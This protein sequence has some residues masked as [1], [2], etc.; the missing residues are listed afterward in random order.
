MTVIAQRLCID[1]HRRTAR[2]ELSAEVDLGSV[3]PDHDALYAAVDRDHLTQAMAHLAPRHREVLGLREGKGWSYQHIADHLD[4]PVTTI[5]ALLHR[6][7]H[8]LR[9]EFLTVSSGSRL[10]GTPIIGWLVF[11]VTRLRTKISGRTANQLVPL[12]G[13]AAAGVAAIG[14]VLNPLGAA[15]TVPTLTRPPAAVSLASSATPTPSN[16][17]IVVPPTVSSASAAS[18]A[19]A[20]AD[21]PRATVSAPPPPIA[22]A[23][24]VAVHSGPAGTKYAQQA[25]SEQPV[26]VDLPGVQA[27]LNPVQTVTDVLNH[28]PGG[29][30]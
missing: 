29:T 11:R 20:A 25:N 12:A 1:H 30:P 13:S 18:A 8:A 3:E 16:V 26:Q 7:R 15:P 17:S 5:E 22:S 9:R 27:G 4:V 24:P 28:L 6:A 14:L 10:A 23:G 19:S 2:V 21:K